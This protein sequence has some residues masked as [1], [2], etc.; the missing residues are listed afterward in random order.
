MKEVDPSGQL[1]GQPL[2]QRGK[3]EDVERV[4]DRLLLNAKLEELISREK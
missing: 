2:S 4:D 3:R 1:R